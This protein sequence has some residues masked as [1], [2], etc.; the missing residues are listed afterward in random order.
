MVQGTAKAVARPRKDTAASDGPA[1]D[2]AGSRLRKITAAEM[3]AVPA[4]AGRAGRPVPAKAG[5]R[6]SGPAGRPRPVDD[7]TIYDS[8]YTA[9]VEHIIMPG[10][11]L[12]E[13]VL[14]R[15]FGVSRTRIRKV[16]QALAHDNLV[17]LQHNR[18]ASVAK[19]GVQE[20]REVFAARRVV[21]TGIAA[22]LAR[23]AAARQITAAQMAS[24]RAFVAREHAAE[25]ARDRRRSINLAGEFHLELAKLLDNASLAGFLRA[26]VSR[27][28]LIIA[29]YEAPGNSMCSHEEHGILLDRL[30]AGDATGAVAYMEEHLQRLEDGL[31]LAAA[32]RRPVDLQDVF[33]RLATGPKTGG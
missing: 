32:R 13:D 30:A 11:K 27:T 20:A 6:G 29:V 21:E 19:P 9:I 31:D 22:E 3:Q 7:A 14:A 1:A 26:L 4:L 18:G 5:S 2:R 16:L 17:T 10:T 24:M 8:V 33:A 12:P 25:T 28:S 15:A 23:R